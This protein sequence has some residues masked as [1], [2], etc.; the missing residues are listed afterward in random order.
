[1]LKIVAQSQAGHRMERRELLGVM[2]V[3]VIG[4]SLIAF[5]PARAEEQ[6]H[7]LV[8][9]LSPRAAETNMGALRAGL[10]ELGYVEAQN[11][12]FAMGAVA[13]CVEMA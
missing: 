8:A 10:A 11:I 13:D 9:V 3:S 7:Q 2:G 4:G 12:R 1:M 6:S 5:C